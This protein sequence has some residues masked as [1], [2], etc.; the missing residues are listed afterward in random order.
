[1]LLRKLLGEVLADMG[2]V[3]KQ[4]GADFIMNKPFRPNQIKQAVAN[5]LKTK[6]G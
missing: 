3:T 2:V 4:K 6:S 1:M 5:A